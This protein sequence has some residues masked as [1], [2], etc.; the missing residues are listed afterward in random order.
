MENGVKRQVHFG[1]SFWK[2]SIRGIFQ[3]F[4]TT[5]ILKTLFV[6]LPMF[7]HQNQLIFWFHLSTNFFTYTRLS[8]FQTL[9]AVGMNRC[10][11]SVQRLPTRPPC[12]R[13]HAVLCMEPV[14]SSGRTFMPIQLRLFHALSVMGLRRLPVLRSFQWTIFSTKRNEISS[15]PTQAGKQEKTKGHDRRIWG[16]FYANKNAT[17]P[18]LLFKKMQLHS[19]ILVIKIWQ[20]GVFFLKHQSQTIGFYLPPKSMDLNA[21]FFFYPDKTIIFYLADSSLLAY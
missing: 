20:S 17:G 3:M 11:D 8:S 4:M 6:E 12:S 19:C 5:C 15:Q 21:R 7:L 1:T 16:V 14:C 13:I 18:S 10:E 9:P 2:P